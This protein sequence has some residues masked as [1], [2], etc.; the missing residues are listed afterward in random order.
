MYFPGND[1]DHGGAGR[2]QMRPGQ[3]DFAKTAKSEDFSFGDLVDTLNP[4]QHIPVVS[5]LYRELTGDQI[6]AAPRMMGSVLYGG[7]TGMVSGLANAVAYQD[8]G[9]DLGEHAVA[10]VFGDGTEDA[11]PQ[12]TPVAAASG[13]SSGPVVMAHRGRR[14]TV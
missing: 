6:A 8:S 3:A 10:M 5:S 13:G 9:K 7:A 14:G 2:L 11:G 12:A 4:L 1:Q